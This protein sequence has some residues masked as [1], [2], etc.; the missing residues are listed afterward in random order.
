M[1]RAIVASLSPLLL[2]FGFILQTAPFFMLFHLSCFFKV[3]E[4]L[5]EASKKYISSLTWEFYIMNR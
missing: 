1:F 5:S 2:C 3:T 4:F